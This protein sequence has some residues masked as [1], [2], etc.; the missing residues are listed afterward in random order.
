MSFDASTSSGPWAG[1]TRPDLPA[2]SPGRCH[3]RQITC[4]NCAACP[5]ASRGE[6]SSPHIPSLPLRTHSLPIYR[7]PKWL[8]PRPTNLIDGLAVAEGKRLKA[9]AEGGQLAAE[10]LGAHAGHVVA[11]LAV[12]GG[13]R[14]A[15]LKSLGQGKWARQDLTA[16]PEDLPFSEGGGSSFSPPSFQQ[17]NTWMPGRRRMVDECPA[18]CPA[19]SAALDARHRRDLA[20]PQLRTPKA[21]RKI[22]QRQATKTRPRIERRVYSRASTQ[23]LLF[24]PSLFEH[25][26]KERWDC[27]WK[28]NGVK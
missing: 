10:V 11:K 24:Q 5:Q 28:W 3:R 12:L 20:P 6:G 25:E 1:P 21:D 7:H 15:A 19:G 2:E 17:K 13:G 27:G 14:A 23:L 18:G 4:A 8:F 22:Q 26:I 16:S 9:G